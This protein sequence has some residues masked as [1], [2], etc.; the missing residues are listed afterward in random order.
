MPHALP[1]LPQVCA[2]DA[3]DPGSAAQASATLD[4]PARQF[5]Q[6]HA[7]RRHS[8]G[9]GVPLAPAKNSLATAYPLFWTILPESVSN[10]FAGFRIL[11][12]GRQAMKRTVLVA[13]S[14]TLVLL[15]AAPGIRP[16]ADANSYP[17]HS[18]QADFSIGAFL[19][20]SEQAKKMFKLDLN[21]AGY[22]VVEIGV[23]PAPGKDVDLYPADF[24]LSVGEKAALRPVS[25]DTISE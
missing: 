23:F 7:R 1:P 15:A 3:H 19:L 17:E 5:C 14:S 16:R 6:E 10:F 8:I 11:S 24:T 18:D 9:G 20:P 2:K 22:I 25:A 12:Q 21:H 4:M 13:L